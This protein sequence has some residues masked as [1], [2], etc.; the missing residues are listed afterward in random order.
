[1]PIPKIIDKTGGWVPALR[2]L[3]VI[4]TAAFAGLTLSLR[5]DLYWS[6]ILCAAVFGVVNFPILGIV[7]EL[8]MEATFP[9]LQPA[10]ASY[11]IFA[12]AQIVSIILTPILG[13]LP[14]K[15]VV[16]WVLVGVSAITVVL[17]FVYRG[18]TKRVQHETTVLDAQ[19]V[20]RALKAAQSQAA[21]GEEEVDIGGDEAV[22][23]EAVQGKTDAMGKP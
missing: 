1:M 20:A 16:L 9:M 11:L 13:G 6:I 14:N 17:S 2:W 10:M 21:M 19:K 18:K 3:L 23:L 4:T 8:S 15:I 7:F 22:K 12:L 5:P